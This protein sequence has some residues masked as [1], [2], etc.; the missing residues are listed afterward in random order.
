[1]KYLYQT[2]GHPHG[3]KALLMLMGVVCVVRT[4]APLFGMPEP[5]YTGMAAMLAALGATYAGRQHTERDK[6]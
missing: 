2:N 1:M 5:D 6:G 3:T 4:V